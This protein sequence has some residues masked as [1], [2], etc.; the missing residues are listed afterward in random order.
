ML[1][2]FDPLSYHS[3]N[4]AEERSAHFH[5]KASTLRSSSTLENHPLQGPDTEEKV[6]PYLYSSKI[7]EVGFKFPF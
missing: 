1:L 2:T 5:Q 7:L 6:Q 3:D 4:A